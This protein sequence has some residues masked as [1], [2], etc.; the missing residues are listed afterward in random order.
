M[1]RVDRQESGFP[2]PTSIP[3][4]EGQK[5]R[6]GVPVVAGYMPAGLL[7]PDHYS[8]PTYDPR[9]SKGYQ[10]PLQ[11]SRVNELVADLKK[12]R[13][14]LPTAVLLNL[15]NRDARHAVQGGLL[16]LDE[17]RDSL[18]SSTLVFH[19]VDGQHRVEALRKLIEEDPTGGWEKFLIPFVCMMGASE[20]QEMEQFYVV[21]SRAKSVRT[22]LAFALLRKITDRDP[23]MLERLEE[24]GRGWQV[25]AEKLV[26]ALA[27][28]SSVWRGLI[29]LA[30][31]EKGNTTMPSASMV[32]SMKPLLASSFFGRLTF[33]L[34]QNVIE[35]FWTGLREVMR[36]AFDE[37]SE[38][39]VQKGVGV[40]VLHAI[41]VDAIEIARS[42]GKSVIDAATYTEILE[43]L[44][45]L[46]GEAQDGV[47]TP[48]R[49]ADF[50]RTAPLGAA[51]SYSS[52][53]GRRLLISKIRQL[54]PKVEV[55]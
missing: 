52:S 48:V 3:V 11:D 1:A 41:L 15:R 9:T 6:T 14:D 4:V 38:F 29:R 36:P 53:A 24:K 46:Q 39:V 8:I 50:W 45:E 22:D 54:L 40:I 17:L 51:G 10:R 7:V 31:M 27:E 20:Q 25:A 28:S 30:G 47:G 13:V 44:K 21:N 35:A 42:Q 37:P 55:V 26:E 19:V 43:S 34:Q 33:E 16:R 23:K 18:L 12:H 49:G 32:T 2:M 5:L